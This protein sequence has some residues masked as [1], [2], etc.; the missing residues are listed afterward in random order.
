[1][2]PIWQLADDILARTGAFTYW[3]R[4]CIHDYGDAAC[5]NI[6][7]VLAGAMAADSRLLVVEQIL[8]NPP[9]NFSAWNDLMILCFGGKERTIADFE[10]LAKGAGL[11]ITG[12]FRSKTSPMGVIEMARIE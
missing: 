11:K 12:I 9:N 5:I 10:A 4:R 1:M 2:Y 7:S 6:M 8:D 3:I